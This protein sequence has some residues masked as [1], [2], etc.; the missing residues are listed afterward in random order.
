MQF[1]AKV[2]LIP[3]PQGKTVAFAT[4]TINDTIAIDGFRI[5]AGDKGDFVSA[6]SEKGRKA[7]ENGKFPYWDKVRFF[8]DKEEGTF[9]GPIQEQAYTAILAA[10]AQTKAFGNRK[11]TAAAERPCVLVNDR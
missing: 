9:R 10:Y 4:L 6:P 11:D 2:N 7:D 5:I 3:N 1:S 8:E